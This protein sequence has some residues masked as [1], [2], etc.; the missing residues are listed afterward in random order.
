[1]KKRV[2]RQSWT[3]SACLFFASASRGVGCDGW[4]KHNL[5]M[6]HPVIG[7]GQVATATLAPDLPDQLELAENA[8][9]SERDGDRL[10]EGEEKGRRPDDWVSWSAARGLDSIAIINR[11]G[12]SRR[13][14]E[15]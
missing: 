14:Q 3:G 1:M 8:R 11:V 13:I 12:W 2:K 6:I 7:I 4:G 5:E 15:A 10:S 9:A